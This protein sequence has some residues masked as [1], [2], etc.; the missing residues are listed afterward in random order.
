MRQ[1]TGWS[2][3]NAYRFSWA[4]RFGRTIRSNT[5]SGFRKLVCQYSR[6][7]SSSSKQMF[8]MLKDLLKSAI[9]DNDPVIFM[10]SRTNVWR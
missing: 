8:M 4:N 6:I 9:R 1:M 2:I 7:K 5:L 10:E 3:S